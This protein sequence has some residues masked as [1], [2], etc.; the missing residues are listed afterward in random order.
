M[1][2]LGKKCVIASALLHGTLAVVLL[3]GPAFLSAPR[4]PESR[5]IIDFIP[6]HIIEANLTG[7]GNPNVATPPPQP[8]PVV[9]PPPQPQPPPPQPQPQPQPQPPPPPPQPRPQPQAQPQPQPPPTPRPIELRPVVRNPD[10]RPQPDTRAQE[11]ARAEAEAKRRQETVSQ[12]I[13]SIRANT[14]SKVEIG[15]VRGP[16]GGGPSYASFEAILRSRY[17]NGWIA[18]TDATLPDAVVQATVTIASDGTVLSA[19]ITQP[20]GDP[21]VDRSVRR[22]LEEVTFIA[23]FPPGAKEKQRTYPLSFSLKAKRGTG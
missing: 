21:A 12:S 3:V 4:P 22:V 1:D 18:P 11:R 14:G 23:P 19:R 15:E 8:Q 2:R 20:S 16:G 13:A 10:A 7:G 17:F 9:Q 6:S 5:D